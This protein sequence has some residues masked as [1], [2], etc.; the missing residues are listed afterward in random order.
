MVQDTAITMAPI[1]IRMVSRAC[2]MPNNGAVIAG[3]HE[4]K[5][6]FVSTGD[7][8]PADCAGLRRRSAQYRS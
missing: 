5:N 3:L 1:Q 7:E 8:S 2:A 6:G 4:V